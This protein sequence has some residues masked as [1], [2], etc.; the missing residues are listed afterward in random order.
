MKISR[1][2]YA[3]TSTAVAA[4]LLLG[5]TA[6]YSV[7]KMGAFVTKLGNVNA[8]KVY[9]S[10]DMHAA[11]S[12]LLAAEQ[13]VLLASH[14]NAEA[15]AKANNS[16]RVSMSR[17][18]EDLEKFTPLAE[19]ES[20][21]RALVEIQSAFDEIGSNHG[22]LTAAASGKDFDQAFQTFESK[23]LPLLERIRDS[24]K[25]QTQFQSGTLAALGS[26]AAA[27]SFAST[28]LVTI[29]SLLA[30]LAAG[31]LYYVI[32]KL[33]AEISTAVTQISQSAAE[34]GLASTQIASASQRLAQ[35][36]CEQ[37]ASLEE[38]SA[39]TEEIGSMTRRNSENSKSAAD[40][41]DKS[42]QGF[43]KSNR[44]LDEMLIAMD[45]ISESSDK[46]SRIIKV[47]DEIAFQTN[48]LALN[49]AVE[50]AR[51]G[52]AGMGFAVVA[53]EVRNL[54]QRCA[55]A[56]KD[57]AALIENSITKSR[58]G[59]F[60]V[61]ETVSAI[62]TVSEQA[63]QMKTLIDE[64]TLGSIE[65]TRGIEQISNALSQM[66]QAT[67]SSA[68]NAEQSASAS[69]QL[70]RQAASLRTAIGRVQFMFTGTSETSTTASNPAL[71]AAV[72]ATPVHQ[73]SVRNFSR[74][75]SALGNATAHKKAEEFPLEESFTEF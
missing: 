21:K 6:W 71:I 61:T 48:I 44:L 54:A 69:Q 52:E 67:Q 30:A 25:L 9:L 35:A 23:V 66:D 3:G 49:A 37:A 36:S 24:S 5:G 32:R 58:D 22:A 72:S 46:I 68:S 7:S 15:L 40:L 10:G 53:D 20:E 62:R 13:S 27:K 60:K 43:T 4:T 75:M 18:R 31:V 19:T 63:G 38:T 74:S 8:K 57:T 56:A 55:Q 51:A 34:V 39:S 16:F 33:N 59:K 1:K 17:F 26:D 70:Q 65:Q 28:A 11:T 42:V 41:V 29:F 50:A 64:V 47:I 45:G 14:H 2:L 73:S 12:S